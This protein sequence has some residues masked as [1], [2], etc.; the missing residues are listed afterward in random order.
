MLS[1]Q[2]NC[3]KP[4]SFKHN[5]YIAPKII[6]LCRPPALTGKALIIDKHIF[7]KTAYPSKIDSNAAAL[8]VVT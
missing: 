7:K 4:C 5:I 8:K 2:A 3:C 6:A 1:L